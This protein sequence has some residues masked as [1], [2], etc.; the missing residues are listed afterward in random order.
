MNYKIIKSIDDVKIN[1]IDSSIVDIR[2]RV[3]G[4][5]DRIL[6]NKTLNCLKYGAMLLV[7]C[8]K[9]RLH[10]FT[11][12]I[13]DMGFEIRDVIMWFY[14]SKDDE[15]QPNF[16]GIIVARKPSSLSIV[17][18]VEKYGVGGINIDEC[19]IPLEDNYI[20]KETNRQPRT[21][22]T[23]FDNNHSG[24]KSEN[25][26]TAVAS[27]KG[28]FPANVIFTYDSS[29]YDVVCGGFPYTKNSKRSPSNSK[30][31]AYTNTYTPTQA[32]YTDDNTYGDDGSASRYFY[33]ATRSRKDSD[34]TTPVNLLQY[35]IRLVSP[36]N[37]QILDI[38][39]D[40]GEIG[41]ATLY[42]NYEHNKNYTYIGIETDPLLST[43][44]T[45]I[46]DYIES[47]KPINKS[48]I[49]NNIENKTKTNIKIKD[50]Q[51]KLF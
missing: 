38:F 25:N 28:R 43:S 48:E 37:S 34:Y 10:R 14:D 18:N 23:V 1:S 19:R 40:S 36:K 31:T 11:C 44:A 12:F 13:E 26:S 9:F 30:P 29:D 49:Q 24:F 42:E 16:S 41:K 47:M 33:C 4:V 27:P 21:E 3:V 6:W 8:D 32:I 39:M 15:I 45:S 22:D 50:Q 46:Y 7:I 17:D 35:I 20:Y 2:N 5:Y 51:R